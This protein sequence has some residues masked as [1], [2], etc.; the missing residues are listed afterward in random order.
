MPPRN[1][2][3]PSWER[4][5]PALV[6]I[7]LRWTEKNQEDAEDLAQ[8]ALLDFFEASSDPPAEL[9]ELVARTASIMKGNF[10]NKRKGEKRRQDPRWLPGAANLSRGLRRTPED[11]AA[12][13][14]DK[15]RLLGA[16][17]EELAGDAP[18]RDVVLATL[19]GFDRAADQAAHLK[20]DIDDIRNIRKRVTRAV[21]A[22]Q[23]HE[24]DSLVARDWEADEGGRAALDQRED[25]EEGEP[26]EE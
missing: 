26:A 19:E 21:A 11:L 14:E 1:P 23:A 22:I 12:A 20:R 15:A 17:L 5:F 7:A 10:L 3:N 2:Q 16:L 8:Q 13:R 24:R 25:G 4:A 9:R 6:A 18:A